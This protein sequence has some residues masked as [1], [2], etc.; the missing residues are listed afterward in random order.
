MA[1]L[2]YP[3]WVIG[4]VVCHWTLQDTHY[5][6]PCYQD[7]ESNQLYLIHRNKHREAANMRRQKKH[8]PN[9][10]TEQ[11]SRK[12]TKKMEISNLSDAELKTLVIRMLKEL[13]EDLNSIKK[14]QSEMNDILF[15]INS[16]QGNSGVMKLRIKSMIWNIRKKK[17]PIRTTKR[18][19]NPK[20]KNEDSI[21]SLWDN[22]KRS[23]IRITWV[24]EEEKEQVIGNLSEKIV[25]ENCPNLVKEVDIQV[26]EAQRVPNKMDAKRPTPRHIK[27]KMPKVKDKE[28]IIKA[29]REKQLFTYREIPI[30]LS[31]D[32]SK[33]TL[34]SRKDLQEIFKVMKSR[35]LQPR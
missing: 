25:K 3:A 19:K 10:R 28:R 5:I 27:I 14:I 2:E 23:N 18:K 34:Q 26:Q 17:Q 30:R 16:L 6:R 7:M 29:A 1:H 21:S 12:R 4:E 32:F 13:S 15:E 33:E 35:G 9:E 8:G 11:N 31:A 20:K 22:F 24:P